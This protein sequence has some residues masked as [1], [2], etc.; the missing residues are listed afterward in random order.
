MRKLN[1]LLCCGA[2]FAPVLSS[3]NEDEI[4]LVADVPIPIESRSNEIILPDTITRLHFENEEEFF[5]AMNSEDYNTTVPCMSRALDD[6]KEPGAELVQFTCLLDTM[7]NTLHQKGRR[8]YDA[9]GY[10]TLVP[11]EKFAKLLN[12]KGEIEIGDYVYRINQEGTFKYPKEKAEELEDFIANAPKDGGIE[13]SEKMFKFDRDLML[14][15]TFVDNST[16]MI[17]YGG[18]VWPDEDIDDPVT[19]I[20]EPDFN[21]FATYNVTYDVIHSNFLRHFLGATKTFTLNFSD[22]RRVRGSFYSYSYIFYHE[23]GIKGWTDKKVLLGWRKTNADELRVGWR[24]VIIEEKFTPE[25]IPSANAIKK[26]V[27][28]P[29]VPGLVN[30]KIVNVGVL[31]ISDTNS[32]LL[33]S[34]LIHG[35]KAVFDYLRRQIPPS[36]DIGKNVNE[37]VA[38]LIVASRNKMYYICNDGETQKFDED[39]YCHVFSKEWTIPEI[40]W[41]NTNGFGIGG[42]NQTNATELKGILNAIRI[43]FTKSDKKMISGETYVCARFSDKWQGM[44]IVLVD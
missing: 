1:Y 3:C 17:D 39:Y 7:P 2:I 44:K 13:I 10:D 36:T 34:V 11:N 4:Q 16:P 9:L 6:I 24:K 15:K 42:V 43:V 38:A 41:S 29:T 18:T 12:V 31:S 30:G 32:S 8:F 21:S 14:F 20:P 37:D 22:K 28:F 23:M 35:A 19:T 33:Q 5:A 40:N 27:Y 25:K 26:D